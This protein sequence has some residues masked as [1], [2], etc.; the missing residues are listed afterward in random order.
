MTKYNRKHMDLI[1]EIRLV[2][3][4]LEEEEIKFR[5]SNS[6]VVRELAERRIQDYEKHLKHLTEKLELYENNVR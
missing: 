1:D 6:R 2:E 4:A 5:N 3:L